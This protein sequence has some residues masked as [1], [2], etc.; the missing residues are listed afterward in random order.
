MQ[1]I[2]YWIEKRAY[3]TPNRVA[4]IRDGQTYTYKE[5]ANA[6]TQTVYLLKKMIPLKKGERVAVLSSNNTTYLMMFFA[7]AKM[8]CI[9]VPLNTRLSTKELEFQINDSQTNYI[10]S[11]DEFQEKGNELQQLTGVKCLL[12]KSLTEHKWESTATNGIEHFISY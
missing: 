9:I 3:I 1:G 5:M 4:L 10:F 7:L 11:S 8:G 6:I 12:M 2:A